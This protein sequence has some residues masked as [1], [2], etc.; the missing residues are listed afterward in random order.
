MRVAHGNTLTDTHK[1]KKEEWEC[2]DCVHLTG[3]PKAS[4]AQPER[5]EG[6]GYQSSLGMATTHQVLAHHL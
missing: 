4:M 5:G 1:K 2:L 6:P 3:S